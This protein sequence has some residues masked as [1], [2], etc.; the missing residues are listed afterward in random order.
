M[1]RRGHTRSKAHTTRSARTR[2]STAH[3]VKHG[4]VKHSKDTH[5]GTKK[6]HVRT[7]NAP[8]RGW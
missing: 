1:V 2:T 8:T 6:V 5:I 4:T 3:A 7:V